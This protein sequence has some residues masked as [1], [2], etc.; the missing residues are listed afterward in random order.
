MM[1]DKD[2]YFKTSFLMNKH[3]IYVFLNL[4][5]KYT[6]RMNLFYVKKNNKIERIMKQGKGKCPKGR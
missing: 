3:I 2:F 1:F 5:L 6:S 4:E